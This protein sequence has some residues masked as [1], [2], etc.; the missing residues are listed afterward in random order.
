MTQAFDAI[1]LYAA[2]AIQLFILGHAIG[3]WL[4]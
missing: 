1:T 4:A 2:I 3:A